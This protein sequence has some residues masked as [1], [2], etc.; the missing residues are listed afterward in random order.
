M[1]LRTHREWES[2]FF[3]LSLL[4][5]PVNYQRLRSRWMLL[6]FIWS[7]LCLVNLLA[8]TIFEN[9]CLSF[10]FDKLTSLYRQ[11]W[12]CDEIPSSQQR[13]YE[14]SATVNHLTINN[15]KSRCLNNMKSFLTFKIINLTQEYS[16]CIFKKFLLWNFGKTSSSRHRFCFAL[17]STPRAVNKAS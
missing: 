4:A 15:D 1:L 14:K 13:A 11:N 5:N 2:F 7:T 8:R 10:F 12:T 17:Y 6:M 3:F 16:C 9:S